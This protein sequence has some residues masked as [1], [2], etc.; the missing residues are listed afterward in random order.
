MIP[1]ALEKTRCWLAAC[2][3]KAPSFGD[4]DILTQG[5]AE[6]RDIIEVYQCIADVLAD[7]HA[8]MVR[9]VKTCQSM[10]TVGSGFGGGSGILEN[11]R[12]SCS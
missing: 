8:A 5:T 1:I 11:K 4:S 2:F 10:D 12:L 9:Q 3:E 7:D 6:Q